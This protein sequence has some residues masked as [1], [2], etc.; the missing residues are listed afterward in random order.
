[1]TVTAPNSKAT[2]G[3]KHSQSE[4]SKPEVYFIQESNARN[5]NQ[6]EK[7]LLD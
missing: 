7:Q 6:N 1:M 4:V 3:H 2:D 5:V